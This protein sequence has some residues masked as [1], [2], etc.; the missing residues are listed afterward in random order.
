MGAMPS[1]KDRLSPQQI[2]DIAAYVHESTTK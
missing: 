1:F 2:A